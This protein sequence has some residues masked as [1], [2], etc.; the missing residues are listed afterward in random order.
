MKTNYHKFWQELRFTSNMSWVN[1]SLLRKGG[2]QSCLISA[3]SDCA[4]FSD[5]EEKKRKGIHL[6]K[7]LHS[8]WPWQLL[9]FVFVQEVNTFLQNG[10]FDHFAVIARQHGPELL[11]EDIELVSAFFL[12][13]VSGLAVKMR[14]K[15]KT[16]WLHDTLFKPWIPTKTPG[17][18]SNYVAHE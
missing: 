2:F 1:S 13:L 14:C 7:E 18:T 17:N 10:R 4:E 15:R 9:T 5:K 11:K 6:E 12:R 8:P 3:D 16:L